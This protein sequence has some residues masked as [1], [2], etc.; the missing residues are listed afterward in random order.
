MN[1]IEISSSEE[2]TSKECYNYNVDD[3]RLLFDRFVVNIITIIIEMLTMNL[4]VYYDDNYGDHYPDNDNDESNRHISISELNSKPSK[5]L[6][7]KSASTMT[8]QEWNYIKEEESEDVY[9]DDNSKQERF[10]IK[11]DNNNYS[12]AS[13]ITDHIRRTDDDN[14]H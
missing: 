2:L 14:Q 11:H 3:I 1:N 4:I 10:T 8:V 13:M 12:T 5:I 7:C 9:S 6:G